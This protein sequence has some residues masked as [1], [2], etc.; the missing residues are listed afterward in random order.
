MPDI[1]K[2]FEK[3]TKKRDAMRL[4]IRRLQEELELLDAEV[5]LLQKEVAKHGLLRH[6]VPAAPTA[7]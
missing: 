7:P 2:Q 3:L 1:F 5:A 6:L 4:R